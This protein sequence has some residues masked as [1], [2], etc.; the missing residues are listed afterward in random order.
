LTNIISILGHAVDSANGRIIDMME[1]KV[2][3]RLL[4]VLNTLQKKF[5]QELNFTSGDLAELA[6]TTSESAL[7]AMA[8]LRDMGIIKTGRGRISILDPERLKEIGYE[9][10]W[11]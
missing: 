3:Q 8:R 4:K 7:R 11:V 2:E 5:G 9:I 1:K 6:G 10:F